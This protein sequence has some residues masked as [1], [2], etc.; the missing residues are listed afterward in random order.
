M[1]LYAKE[2]KKEVIERTPEERENE[3]LHKTLAGEK[4][5]LSSMD[6]RERLAYIWAYYKL[7]ILAVVAVCA[8]IISAIH[9]ALTYQEPMLGGAVVNDV[10]LAT[11]KLTQ[12]FCR[13]AGFNEHQTLAMYEDILLADYDGMTGGGIGMGENPLYVHLAAKELDFVLCDADGLAYLES[14]EVCV[15]PA[16]L[17][18]EEQSRQWEERIHGFGIDIT[19]T[20]AAEYLG[21]HTAPSYL[22]LT[23]LSGHR[24]ELQTFLAFLSQL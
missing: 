11:E 7:H 17:L 20:S 6:A 22:C 18:T 23:D 16:D 5:K 24:E 13:Y 21:V 9:H 3:N 12:D 14:L 4:R 19:G 8:I 1:K 15:S 2:P 10:G